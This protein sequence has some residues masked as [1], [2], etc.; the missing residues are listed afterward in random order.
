[1]SNK[2]LPPRFYST[3]AAAAFL[4]L[5]P[6]TLEGLRVR[7]GGPHYHK[8]GRRC[9]YAIKDLISWAEARR[10]RSTSE[11]GDDPALPCVRRGGD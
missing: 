4:G 7:G 2:E 1:M 6:R 3:S 8:L 9:M 11:A 5:S 10:R